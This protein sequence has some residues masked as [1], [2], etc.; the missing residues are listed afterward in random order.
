V[1]VT[2]PP[3]LCHHQIKIF[4]RFFGAV[5]VLW[6]ASSAPLQ[7][8]SSKIE[9]DLFGLKPFPIKSVS[10]YTYM[11]NAFGDSWDSFQETAFKRDSSPLI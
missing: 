4:T 5:I 2:T 3:S 10:D 9:I 6:L 7:A 11:F 8:Q 1:N